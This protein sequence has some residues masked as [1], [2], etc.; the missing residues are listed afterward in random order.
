MSKDEKNTDSLM[1][2]NNLI[3]SII[4]LGSNY[5]GSGAVF[6]YLAGRGDILD[7]LDGKELN[8]IH[9]PYG[10]L[11]FISTV[12]DS[13]YPT[14]AAE[15]LDKLEWI[16]KQGGYPKR[17]YNCGYNLEKYIPDYQIKIQHYINN[18][19]EV[20]YPF[21]SQHFILN[22][23]RWKC[24]VITLAERIFQR[25]YTSI[26]RLPVSKERFLSATSDFLFSLIQERIEKHPDAKGSIL[27][28]A[29]S[30]WCPEK[31]LEIFKNPRVIIVSRDPRDQ[32]VSLKKKKGLTDVKIFVQWYLSVMKHNSDEQDH[33]SSN[34]IKIQYED[35][36][37]NH[38][39]EKGRLCSFLNID[40][41]VP[42][43]YRSDHSARNIGKYNDALSNYE[44]QYIE[45]NLKDYICDI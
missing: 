11:P 25:R 45:D 5:S 22:Q 39:L 42:S 6:D 15:A 43:D 4:V 16:L 2:K 7:P 44:I 13:F 17:G 18:I 3:P 34:I 14:V 9:N 37:L 27:N 21:R 20:R 28:Q 36:V 10:I 26:Q 31:S 8:I 30:Y 23:P 41:T 32:F 38:D 12:Y 35:F 19:T 33:F 1:N 29:G 24:L 40:P